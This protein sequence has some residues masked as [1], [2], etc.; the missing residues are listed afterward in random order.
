MIS[1]WVITLIFGL[2]PIKIPT[3]RSNKLLLSYS[4]CF[5]GGLF[6]A[7]G[8]IH[9]LPEA[10]ENLEGKDDHDH[11]DHD[12]D[13]HDHDH[14]DHDYL[15]HGDHPFPWSFFICLA[16]FSIIL[17]IDKVL[18]NSA[19]LADDSV[20][21]IDLNKSVLSNTNKSFHENY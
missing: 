5:A 7:I 1:I 18:F 15:T 3:F 2:L 6:L 20:E 8:L 19:D 9:I 14:L 4:N 11:H 10:R 12:H 13:H 21:H 17:L 16:S